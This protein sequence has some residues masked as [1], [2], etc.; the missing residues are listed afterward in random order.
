[1]RE[2]ASEAFGGLD[3][4][5]VNVG[6]VGMQPLTNWG[7]A[8]FDRSLG[9]IFKGLFFL[10]QAL[11]P[12]FANPAP[13][14]LNTSINARIGMPTPARRRSFRSHGRSQPSCSRAA[15]V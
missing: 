7:E 10:I 2:G 9:I 13:I 11:L 1:M 5:V 3:I 15:S 6:I 12:V 14:G 8:A 4:L